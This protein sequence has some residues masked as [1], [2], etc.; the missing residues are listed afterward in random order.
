LLRCAIY[1]L[2]D[3]H[4]HISRPPQGVK[5]LKK[6]LNL[7]AAPYLYPPTSKSL[8][9]SSVQFQMFVADIGL[10]KVVCFCFVYWWKNKIMCF[11]VQIVEIGDLKLEPVLWHEDSG[12][13][14]H[15]ENG[16]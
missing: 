3:A 13:R 14:H 12:R 11:F 15:S 4:K 1:R 10:S 6:V 7:V 5:F 16:R 2:P 8:S 9:Q